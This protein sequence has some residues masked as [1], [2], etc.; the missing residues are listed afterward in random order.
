MHILLRL[1][2]FTGI[3]FPVLDP[4]T[5]RLACGHDTGGQRYSPLTQINVRNVSKLHA[6]WQYGIDLR[7]DDASARIIP[8]AEAVPMIVSGILY[9]PTLRRIIV[10]LEPESGKEIWPYD[11]CKAG[12]PLRGVTCREGDRTA[13]PQILVLGT[14]NNPRTGQ[15][16]LAKSLDLMVPEVVGAAAKKVIVGAPDL[17]NV[18]SVHELRSSLRC[19]A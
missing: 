19:S 8:P 12:A 4:Q 7:A 13:P 11:F 18:Q 14:V 15:Q 5:D 9:T 2:V 6:A 17:D 1:A 3:L 16:V 10:A